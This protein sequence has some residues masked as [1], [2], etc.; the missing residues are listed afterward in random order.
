MLKLHLVDEDLVCPLELSITELGGVKCISAT[1]SVSASFT[2]GI[3]SDQCEIPCGETRDFQIDGPGE[4]KFAYHCSSNIVAIFMTAA[5]FES[6]PDSALLKKLTEALSERFTEA[7]LSEGL[8]FEDS[9]KVE[10][11]EDEVAVA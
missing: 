7:D 10:V 5:K 6:N 3:G 11:Y 8:S 4:Y 9:F 2:A 1:N